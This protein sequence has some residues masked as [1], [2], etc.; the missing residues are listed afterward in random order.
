MAQPSGAPFGA[1]PPHNQFFANGVEETEP[2]T[3]T[4][5][6]VEA[7]RVVLRDAPDKGNSRA[8]S[9]RTFSNGST[10]VASGLALSTQSP[11]PE[12]AVNE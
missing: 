5:A 1:H 3:F 4:D 7:L 11:P 12:S 2:D 10:E 9:S 6:E 8:A